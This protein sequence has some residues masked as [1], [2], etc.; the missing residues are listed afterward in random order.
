A[1]HGGPNG[2]VGSGNTGGNNERPNF[3]PG[4][5]C[6]AHGGDPLQWLNPNA[7]TLDHYALT[8]APT[9]PRGV[10][11]GPGIANTDFSIRK[12]FK[13]TER[14]TA[15]FSFDFFN[16]FNKPQFSASNINQTLSNSSVVCGAGASTDPN[17][18]W[19]SGG[20]D[21]AGQSF[22]AYADHSLFWKTFETD[23]ALPAAAPQCGG[24]ACTVTQGAN[25]P[26]GTFGLL[27]NDRPAHGPREIQYGL[28][29]E[30]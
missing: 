12:N 13:V 30:F 10:C 20:T 14:V 3:V 2:L 6:R 28:T 18:P 19:C 7:W 15:K 23:W 26:Q 25:G 22:G 27:T 1:G 29:I 11:Y 4:Q 9:S 16:I 21:I 5:S 24:T 8:S 17:Q